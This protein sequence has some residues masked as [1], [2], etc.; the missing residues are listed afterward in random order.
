MRSKKY[1]RERTEK[2][3]NHCMFTKINNLIIKGLSPTLK[4]HVINTFIY[5]HR[6]MHFHYAHIVIYESSLCK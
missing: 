5:I 3:K 2:S 1:K 6:V 4:S